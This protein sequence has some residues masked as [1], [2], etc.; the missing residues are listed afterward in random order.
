MSCTSIPSLY[1]TIYT[2]LHDTTETRPGR[3]GRPESQASSGSVATRS[4][5]REPNDSFAA[6]EPYAKRP[7]LTRQHPPWRLAASLHG[8]P[9]HLTR[10]S[11]EVTMTRKGACQMVG[12]VTK[13]TFRGPG[14]V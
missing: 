2:G 3:F 1:P 11:V 14:G 4:G 6:E 7:T 10:T 9:R 13:L 8:L 12:V 5:V